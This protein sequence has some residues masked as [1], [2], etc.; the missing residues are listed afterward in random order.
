M[1]EV[2]SDNVKDHG[3]RG[4]DSGFKMDCAEVSRASFCSSEPLARRESCRGS[5]GRASSVFSLNKET[6]LMAIHSQATSVF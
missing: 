1:A 6:M 3:D 5:D 2:Q 4:V